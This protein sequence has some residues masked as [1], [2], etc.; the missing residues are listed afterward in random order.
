MVSSGYFHGVYTNSWEVFRRAPKMPSVLG[1]YS[2]AL[3]SIGLW[4]WAVNRSLIEE[5]APCFTCVLAKSYGVMAA[6]GLLMP[7][8]TT[9]WIIHYLVSVLFNALLVR[10]YWY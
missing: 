8:V 3:M 7:M 2:S 1:F 6:C 9:P 4:Q 10:F 5:E